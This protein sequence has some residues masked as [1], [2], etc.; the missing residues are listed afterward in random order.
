MKLTSILAVYT[1][2]WTMTLF[3]V[4][5]WHA[6][7]SEELGEQQLPGHADSAPHRFPA[8]RVALRT[9]LVSAILFGL[10]YANYVFSWIGADVFD[11]VLPANG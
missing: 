5:P 1:L 7:T 2:F 6:R 3:L 11:W 8:G 4:L 10:F 9:T